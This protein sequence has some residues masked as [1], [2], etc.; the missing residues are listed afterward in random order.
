MARVEMFQHARVALQPNDGLSDIQPQ[1]DWNG[2]AHVQ[3]GILG[4]V[5]TASTLS[6]QTFLQTDALHVITG[7][8]STDTL[9][10]I[11]YTNAHGND[12][13]QLIAASG[14]TI[15]VSHGTGNIYLQGGVNKLLN[16]GGPPLL[17][18]FYNNKWYEFGSFNAAIT[19]AAN[20]FS[21]LQ[22]FSGGMTVSGT[23]TINSV[24]QSHIASSGNIGFGTGALANVSTGNYNT[25]FGYYTLNA[26][27]TGT[28]NAGF[29][30][31]TLPNN[32]TGS[33]N[34][35][36]GLNALYTNVTGSNNTAVGFNALF[37]STIDNNSAFGF[38][39]L[40]TNTTGEY[41][42]GLGLN[43][44]FSNTTG[45]YNV[46]SG[47]Y[48]LEQNTT[49]SSNVVIGYYAYSTNT[50][51]NFNTILG[52][53]AGLTSTGSSNIFIGYNAGYNETG[54]GKL[55]IDVSNTA[56]PLIYG[57]FT[58]RILKFNGICTAYNTI[59][60][61]GNGLVSIHGIVGL[62]VNLGTTP[63]TVSSYTPPVTGFYSV[64][65]AISC[66]TTETVTL[67]ISYAD[68]QAGTITN[69]TIY[70][71][72][73]TGGTTDSL[74]FNVYAASGTIITVSG[75]GSVALGDAYASAQVERLQ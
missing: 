70:S 4:F 12:W 43:A 66:K 8:T 62:G 64:R 75:S 18:F 24:I 60:T 50:V 20:T 6:S 71:K 61:V 54:S 30:Y 38:Q 68:P 56:N 10:T 19:N 51:G 26:N 58:A 3:Q 40:Q 59:A 42:T 25:S 53:N 72:A 65:I 52:A 35:A 67:T 49:G 13:L 44:M 28:N 1:R 7:Q 69:Q 16:V 47:H 29:G 2:N 17:L 45:S 57:D 37:Y 46:S 73:L 23:V 21:A 74:T 41:N 63:T 5:G 48:S 14:Q 32:T 11:T 31:Y 36:V 9:A 39:A 33:Q 55:Y 27:T 15:T 22:T 34:T